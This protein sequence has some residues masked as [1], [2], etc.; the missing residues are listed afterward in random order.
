M[1]E[2]K[3]AEYALRLKGLSV[4]RGILKNET[5][6]LFTEMLE[7]PSPD[8]YGSF[9][10]SLYDSGDNLT[11]FL[12]NTVIKD[13]NA[14]MRRL[15]AYKEVP[16]CIEKAA[17]SELALMNTVS[18][19]TSAQ[20]KAA[21]DKGAE[22]VSADWNVS[23][24]DFLKAYTEK[25][26]NLSTKGFG[27]FSE[28]HVF[29]F[30]DG[31]ITPVKNPDPQ[32]LSQLSG[33]EAER[34]KVISNT[35]ALL[36]D[37]PAANVLLYG[38]AG[39][40]KSSTV[41]AVVNEFA[42]RGLRLIELKKAQLHELPDVME[43]IADNPLKF[44]IFIDDLSF[45]SDDADFGALKAVL[46]GSISSKASNAVIYATSNRRHLVKE[47]F[48]D[49][50]GD[51]I[52]ARDTREELASLSERFGLKVTFLKPDKDTYLK[53]VEY[54]AGQYGIEMDRDELFTKAEAYALRRS[55]RSG[56]AA[57]HFV[58][59]LKAGEPENQQ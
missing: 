59:M 8:T 47:S 27:I 49:R 11:E 34:S 17:K 9:V 13:E 10:F 55:G 41:K 28:Y 51:D 42:D 3:L 29:T 23:N 21:F 1:P 45:S 38:D 44:I 26:A 40:G 57:R 37:K 15:A 16:A 7:K 18:Q 33:Y 4:F 31:K 32:K 22:Y 19:L 14:F 5:V 30:K 53:I 58:E 6:K 39:T 12:L 35:L 25:I 20:V 52:H 54:L 46:E 50:S 2:N 48:S 36:N 56:R 43:S 24:I